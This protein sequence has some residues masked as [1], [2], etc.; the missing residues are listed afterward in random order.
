MIIN[1]YENAHSYEMFLLHERQAQIDMERYVNEAIVFTE[2][3]NIADNMAIINEGFIESV[4]E[5]LNK[6]A[7]FLKKMWA[8]FMEIMNRLVRTNNSYLTKYKDVILKTKFADDDS[9]DMYDWKVGKANIM[10]NVIIPINDEKQ[11]MDAM[12]SKD[13]F[14]GK[15]FGNVV[16]GYKPPYDFSD[17]CKAYFRGGEDLKTYNAAELNGFIKDMYDYCI[18]YGEKTKDLLQKDYD[19]FMNTA[20]KLMDKFLTAQKRAQNN[21]TAAPNNNGGQQQGQSESSIWDDE[22]F[23]SSIYEGFVNEKVTVNQNGEYENK[24]ESNVTPPSAPTP[25]NTGSGVKTGANKG[26]ANNN[27]PPKGSGATV[28][29]GNKNDQQGKNKIATDKSTL[30]NIKTDGNG[31]SEEQIK[32]LGNAV[33]DYVDVMN[34]YLTTRMSAAEAMYKDFMQLI[35]Y[36]VSQNAGVKDNA[37]ATVGKMANNDNGNNQ[38]QY[39]TTQT[40]LPQEEQNKLTKQGFKFMGGKNNG[41]GQTTEYWLNDQTGTWKQVNVNS[42]NSSNENN[43]K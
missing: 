32:A 38:Q 14:I 3:V 11:L 12:S 43:F 27:E 33:S 23:Y 21:A 26:G 15:Y 25:K 18:Q 2:G 9:A 28:N 42:G 31:E 35:R 39:D 8:K 22:Y 40:S 19:S 30:N 24:P 29:I 4:K 5:K 1:E 20:S 13:N 16:K 6:V 36:H 37:K 34:I 10:T 41:N 7:A 17:A